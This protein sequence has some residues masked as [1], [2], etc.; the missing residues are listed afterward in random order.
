[1]GRM[2]RQEIESIIGRPFT[3]FADLSAD[4]R[5]AVVASRPGYAEAVEEMRNW[6]PTPGD[7]GLTLDELLE[8]LGLPPAS[9]SNVEQDS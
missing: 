3:S 2:S 4:E 6:K 8:E 1:M 9:S 7:E 5:H